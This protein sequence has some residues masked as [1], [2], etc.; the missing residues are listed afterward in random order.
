VKDFADLFRTRG[1][2]GVH[3][4]STYIK[5]LLS[6]MPGKNMERMADVI[7]EAK[8]QDLQQFVSDSPWEVSPVWDE[9]ASR[10]NARLGNH[11]DSMLVIDESAFAK[12][13][14]SSAGVARQHNGRLGKT[15]NCQVGVFSTLVRGCEATMIGARLFLPDEWTDDLE[16]CK[17]AGIPDAEVVARTKIEQARELIDQALE[18][19]VEFGLVAYDSFY[20]RDQGLLH[21]IH[22]RGLIFLADI[23]VD[24][25]VWTT[26]PA[27]DKRPKSIGQSGAQRADAVTRDEPKPI[28]LRTGENGAV[29]VQAAAKRIWI[30]PG[31][32]EAPLA[33][34]LLVTEQTDG[35]KKFTL[36]N[37]PEGTSLETLVRWQGQRFFIEQTFKTAKSHCG[38][39]DY[40]VRKFHA[41]HHHMAL[42]GL[43][44]LFLLDEKQ[45]CGGS[46]PLLSAC[47]ISEIIHWHF[48]AQPT[49]E[50]VIDAI[51]RRHGRRAKATES[52][53]RVQKKRQ[54]AILKK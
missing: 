39:A 32:A 18:Q 44:L 21:Y 27:G 35:S 6:R 45:S 10:A 4:A 40:Q 41:W 53:L 12:Q 47:D 34:W 30:W 8:Q 5:G 25:F 7:P 50:A 13:G 43:A 31:K 49:R 52:K 51:S 33:C 1:D 14:K 17:K 38:M 28:R 3:H 42:V 46:I 16:R 37:A 54:K 15:D 9:I 22:D 29:T 11:R 23:P 48:C 36:S 24:T 2:S 20:G 19:G 26:K